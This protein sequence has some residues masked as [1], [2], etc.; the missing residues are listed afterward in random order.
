MTTHSTSMAAAFGKILVKRII[1]FIFTSLI[2]V[3]T[4]IFAIGAL[5]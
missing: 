3:V 2:P 1:S 4:L 5:F